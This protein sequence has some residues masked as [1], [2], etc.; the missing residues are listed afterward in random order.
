VLVAPPGLTVEPAAVDVGGLRE[1]DEHEVKVRV[2][3]DAGAANALHAVRVEPTDGA[4]AAAGTLPV[5]VGVVLAEDRS[6]PLV[7][8]TVVRAPG[9]TLKLDHQS[10]VCCQLLDPDGHRRHGP[11]SDG[12]ESYLGTGALRRGQDWVLRYRTP[13]RF[14]FDGPNSRIVVSGSG[15]EQVRLKYT[16]RDDRVVLALVPPTSAAAEFDLFLGP[17]DDLGGPKHDGPAPKKGVKESSITAGWVFFPHP[18]HRHGVLLLPPAAAAVR[19]RPDAI[20]V[21]VRVGQEVTLRFA[22]EAE[23]SGAV[24]E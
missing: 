14:V 22:T 20:A 17:F 12:P 8:Q 24:R 6:I 18:V 11:V 23:L 5:S 15:P 4:N 7:A 3:A 19:P 9:Y 2:Q 21:R 1:G 16:F 10:G 13:C